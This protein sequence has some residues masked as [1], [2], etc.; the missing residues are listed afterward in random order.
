[1]VAHLACID[2]TAYLHVLQ[3]YDDPDVRC[4]GNVHACIGNMRA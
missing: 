4:L 3:A 2:Y 1:M